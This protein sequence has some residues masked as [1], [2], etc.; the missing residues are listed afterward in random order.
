[1]GKVIDI[2]NGITFDTIYN[3][4]DVG[5]LS[6]NGDGT[7]TAS[8]IDT[9]EI[10]N[11]LGEST[12]AIG[13]LNTSS[14]VNRY[15]LFK[16]DRN[17]VS[18]DEIVYS[19]TP[20]HPEAAWGFAAYD[21]QASEDYVSTP[22]DTI[23]VEPNDTVSFGAT[24]YISQ[25]NLYKELEPDVGTPYLLLKVKDS[26]GTVVSEGHTVL[27]DAGG[28]Q[29]YNVQSGQ[30]G[31]TE[32]YTCE[33]WF[34]TYNNGNVYYGKAQNL[35]D[36]WTFSVTIDEMDEPICFV[37]KDSGDTDMTNRTL[38]VDSKS[39]QIDDSYNIQFHFTD[40]DQPVYDG[41]IYAKLNSG[42]YYLI[43]S[44]L[45]W[46][47]DKDYQYS[48]TLPFDVYYDDEVTFLLTT[49]VQSGAVSTH[50]VES[51]S[52]LVCDLDDHTIA[53]SVKVT[54]SY[55]TSTDVTIEVDFSPY[56]DFSSIQTISEVHNI[57]GQ[58]SNTFLID[59][60]AD[61][62]FEGET[63]VYAR[64]RITDASGKNYNDNWSGNISDDVTYT[65]GYVDPDYLSFGDQEST[66]KRVDVI[67]YGQ[68]TATPNDSWI[69]LNGSN[70]SVSGTDTW[71]FD[72]EVAP[73]LDSSPR[74]GSITIETPYDTH[75]ITVDQDGSDD[76]GL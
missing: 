11:T 65:N 26:G 52:N 54:N 2:P 19:P 21:H 16:P 51:I 58:S 38:V 10:R 14:S 56:S 18:G 70:D 75:S 13:S 9:T 66:A 76:G 20:P 8:N 63:E 49:E 4:S 72:V 42:D 59:G 60:T 25:Q 39:V 43:Y 34:G 12:N 57:A 6:D 45:T 23:S 28:G 61:S 15:S 41:K 7:F 22:A 31:G 5:D 47:I 67:S 64:A 29:S 36:N 35:V 53:L 37:H 30:L 33:L 73:N 24:Y 40:E 55:D 71:N 44:S 74:Q 46:T 1:M 32:T 3:N 50:F 17:K 69:Y 62:M 68:S 48:G 27:E